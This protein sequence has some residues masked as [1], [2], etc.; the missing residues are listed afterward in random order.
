[1]SVTDTDFKINVFRTAPE[2]TQF[3]LVEIEHPMLTGVIRIAEMELS[4]GQPVQSRGE[5][6]I[7]CSF[8]FDYQKDIEDQVPRALFSVTNI[9]KPL[10]RWVEQSGGG[11]DGTVKFLTVRESTPDEVDVSS[12][13]AISSCVATLELVTFELLVQKNFTRRG[14]RKVFDPVSAPG[15]F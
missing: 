2:D 15:L 12:K 5:T 3:V 9:G 4:G 6:Y 13:F 10:M 11:K 7:P 14:T 8:D 1:M